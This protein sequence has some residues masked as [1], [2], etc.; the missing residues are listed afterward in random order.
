MR[1]SSMV[2]ELAPVVLYLRHLVRPNDV[3]IIEEP[4]SHLHPAM[5]VGFTRQLAAFV[6]A[7]VRVIVTTHSEWLLEELANLVRLSQIPEA[8][9]TGIAGSDVALDTN[10]V[11]AWLFK[12]EVSG[13]GSTVSEIG[14]DESGLYPSGFDDVAMALHN[15]WAAISSRIGMTGERACQTSW[16]EHSQRV[17]RHADGQGRVQRIPERRAGY[18]ADCRLRQTGIAARPYGRALRLSVRRG[19]CR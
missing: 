17:H 9:R 1:A 4:E 18:P 6:R 13:E 5:Q 16:R 7:G 10:Q 2:S 3:L 14:L 19:R 12:P 15:D 8:E 11:G